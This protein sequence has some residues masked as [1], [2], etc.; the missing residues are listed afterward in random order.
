MSEVVSAGPNGN[1]ELLTFVRK[2]RGEESHKGGMLVAPG[3]LGDLCI[4]S[5]LLGPSDTKACAEAI[6]LTP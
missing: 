5:W 1:P 3:D 6:A 2:A 4:T